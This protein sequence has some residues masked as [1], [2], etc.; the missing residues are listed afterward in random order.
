M[1]E[2][3]R[4]KVRAREDKQTEDTAG[5]ELVPY[6]PED[7]KERRGNLFSM[8]SQYLFKTNP[9]LFI[10]SFITKLFSYLYNGADKSIYIRGCDAQKNAS[11]ILQPLLSQCKITWKKIFLGPCASHELLFHGLS[12]MSNRLHSVVLFL[13]AWCALES[14]KSFSRII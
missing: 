6:P 9:F 4:E 13:W 3:Q 14:G 2:R 1:G 12:T 11:T 10:Q 5:T 7:I 8:F